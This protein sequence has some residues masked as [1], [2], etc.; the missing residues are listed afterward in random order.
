VIDDRP[1][2]V[3]AMRA[4]LRAEEGM[5][6]VEVVVAA[7]I[8]IVG[9]LAVL[10]L[11]DAAT[12]TTY[13]AEQS[14]VIVNQLQAEMERMRQLPFDEMA[15]TGPPETSTDPASPASRVSGTNFAL[16][17]DGADPRPLAVQGGMT[18]T[19]DPVGCG[20]VGEPACGID[21]GPESFESGDVTGKIYRYVVYPE[22]PSDCPGCTQDDLK[23]I[24]VAITLDDTAS[25]GT[26]SYQEIQSDIV[27]DRDR[28]GTVPT[29]TGGDDDEIATF[30]LTDTP[31]D[32]ITRNDV[33]PTDHDTHNTRGECSVGLKSGGTTSGAPDLMFNDQPAESEGGGNPFIDYA[34]DVEPV[35]NQTLDKGLQ[36]LKPTENGSTGCL[37]TAPT[38]SQLD[39]PTAS[40]EP[41]KH[42]KMHTW[43]SNELDPN[44]SPL[45]TSSAT[46]ELFTRTVNGV[47]DLQGKVCYWAFKRVELVG[48]KSGGG[49]VNYHVDLPAVVV[50]NSSLRYGQFTRA[51]WPSDWQEVSMPMNLIFTDVAGWLDGVDLSALGLTSLAVSGEPRLGLTL[52][53][54]KANTTGGGLE[55]MY[56]HPNFASRLEVQSATCI[57]ECS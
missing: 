33:S 44:F 38:T 2:L 28:D 49:T 42:L 7:M 10:G 35:T 41:N 1:H 55:F 30:W 56:D 16:G 54:E 37:L 45:T 29:N 57:L 34:A 46:L 18:A 47:G 5:T 9:A 19:G 13:R 17:R 53:V 14:Q 12:R 36:I 43:L 31:C 8:L 48:V 39:F 51:F 50:N 25:G 15:L 4:R 6:V 27:T 26:R 23:R 32:S 21:P 22:I 24:V 11:A 40:P 52:Q 3:A 20:A